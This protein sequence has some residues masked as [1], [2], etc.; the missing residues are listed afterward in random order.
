MGSTDLTPHNTLTLAEQKT[1]SCIL[2]EFS[3]HEE[4]SFAHSHILK[5]D[6]GLH[7]ILH[8]YNVWN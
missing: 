4:Q 3:W 5:N 1:D 8:V 2:E 7:H 6:N